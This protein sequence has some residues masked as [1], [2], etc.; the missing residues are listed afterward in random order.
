MSKLFPNLVPYGSAYNGYTALLAAG[1]TYGILISKRLLLRPL[2]PMWGYL[3]GLFCVRG[4]VFGAMVTLPCL[5]IF[6]IFLIMLRPLWRACC[7]SPG[8]YALFH[9]AVLLILKGIAYSISL[10]LEVLWT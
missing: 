3:L 7:I 10:L 9:G 5:V 1:E 6:G 4:A 8:A 2:I